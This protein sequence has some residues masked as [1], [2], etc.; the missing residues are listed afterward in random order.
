MRVHP[1]LALA[2]TGAVNTA[3]ILSALTGLS[4][5]PEEILQAGER[6]NNLARAFNSLA[7]CRVQMTLFPSAS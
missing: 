7:D 5:T 4:L 6:V 2:G 1:R 3:A